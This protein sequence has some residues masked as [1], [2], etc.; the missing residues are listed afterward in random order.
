MTCR[1]RGARGGE[2]EGI[3]SL[4][5]RPHYGGPVVDSKRLERATLLFL[6]NWTSNVRNGEKEDMFVEA[7]LIAQHDS[8]KNMRD[9]SHSRHEHPAQQKASPPNPPNDAR[10][11]PSCTL[12]VAYPSCRQLLGALRDWQ[13]KHRGS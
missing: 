11:K 1:E 10:P 4:S 7:V 13:G 3:K 6:V 2:K 9:A 8:A 5:R 12:E